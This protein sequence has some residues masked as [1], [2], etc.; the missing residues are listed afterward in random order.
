MRHRDHFGWQRLAD[1]QVPRGILWAILIGL[2][3]RQRRTGT[4]IDD[5]GEKA[6]ELGTL[7]GTSWRESHEREIQLV[8]LQGSVERMTRWLVRLTI[9]LGLIG[10]A[11]VTV[12]IWASLR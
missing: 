4:A 2:W 6:S 10:I 11:G 12:A 7:L 8:E 5:F 3:I 9:V 1:V